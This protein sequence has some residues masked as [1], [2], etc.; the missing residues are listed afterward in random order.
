MAYTPVNLSDEQ[1]AALEV[2]HEDILV[3]RGKPEVSP[4]VV[5]IRR[6]KRQETIG[7]KSAV[8]RDPTT[9]NEQLLRKICV[10]P[11]AADFERQ[12]DRWPFLCDACAG[13][14]AFNDFLG[15]SVAED[16]KE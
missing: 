9:A 14:Q 12:L 11:Q 5:V 7:Y 6:P 15:L 2:E 8:K 13:S 16:L 4:W 3:L 10:F 1:K